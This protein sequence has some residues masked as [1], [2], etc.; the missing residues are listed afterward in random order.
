MTRTN[1][2][3][4][5]R[6]AWELFRLDA[7]RWKDPGF[8]VDAASLST[9][10][11]AKL[12]YRFLSLRAMAWYRLASLAKVL[13]IP[14][15]PGILQRRLLRVYGLELVPGHEVGGG[16]Y[17]AHP[18]GCTLVAERLGTN[19]TVIAGVTIGFRVGRR[20]PR[21]G[22]GVFLGAGARVLGDID[23]GADA[24]IGANS[25]V[26]DDVPAGATAVGIPAK[27][28]VPAIAG[29]DRFGVLEDGPDQAPG[30]A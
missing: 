20:W 17:I 13:G 24:K 4:A 28:R 16:L 30:M 14:A 1:A 22:D 3:D 29:S 19:V 18:A 6:T 5:S 12:L 26:I 9:S 21:I 11:I 10:D 2:K 25:V 27:V 7:A 23:I 15:V 8:V